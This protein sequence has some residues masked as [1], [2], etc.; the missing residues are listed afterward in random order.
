MGS[1]SETATPQLLSHDDT[2]ITMSNAGQPPEKP[3][4]Q[5]EKAP[6]WAVGLVTETGGNWGIVYSTAGVEVYHVST[7]E[8]SHALATGS[9]AVVD[10]VF[11]AGTV[12]IRVNKGAWTPA[13]AVATGSV[14]GAALR[15]ARNF[16]TA[17][18][19][20]SIME[21]FISLAAQSDADLDGLYEYRKARYA[22]AGLP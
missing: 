19:N 16:G 22:A 15:V 9:W 5:M 1:V 20:G 18:F 21:V 11:S 3:T 7:T 8:V 12:K 17:R 13:A 6:A 2:R 4:T 10:V 14:T